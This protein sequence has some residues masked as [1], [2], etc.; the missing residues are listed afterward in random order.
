MEEIPDNVSKHGL[1]NMVLFPLYIESLAYPFVIKTCYKDMQKKVFR[2][3]FN[4]S[5]THWPRE[6][7]LAKMQTGRQ[8]LPILNLWRMNRLITCANQLIHTDLQPQMNC[9]FGKH[10]PKLHLEFGN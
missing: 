3:H 7:P 9:Q 4:Y 10:E 1:K 8:L 5:A 6:T 2:D